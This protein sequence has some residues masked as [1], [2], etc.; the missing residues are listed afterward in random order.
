MLRMRGCYVTGDLY[1]CLLKYCGNLRP[2]AMQ[3][4][5]GNFGH[6]KNENNWLLRAYPKLE[7]FEINQRYSLSIGDIGEFFKRNQQIR[8]FTIDSR[9]FLL[10][11]DII[12][13][14]MPKLDKLEIR[15]FRDD[16]AIW[17]FDELCTALNEFYEKGRYEILHIFIDQINQN[18]SEQLTSLLYLESLYIRFFKKCYNLTLLTNLKELAI[19][20][21]VNFNE[22]EL[23]ADALVNLEQIF[24]SNATVNDISP[25]IKQSVKLK[26]IKLL[27]KDEECEKNPLKL[28]ILNNERQKVL[29]AQKVMIFVSNTLFS[30]TKLATTNGDFNLNFVEVRRSESYYWKS[31]H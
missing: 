25:F 14:R 3:E 5:L 26:K 2:L 7:H 27:L 23:L 9:N 6:S 15:D 12:M 17:E 22:M 24:L 30:A 21:G 29:G 11:K 13:K 16:K 10:H 8:S 28:K 19:F 4:H 18:E 1:N 20:D 31:F